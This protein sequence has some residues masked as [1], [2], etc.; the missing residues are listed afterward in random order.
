[1]QQV[2]SSEQIRA[3]KILNLIP[4]RQGKA[5]SNSDDARIGFKMIFITLK[6][7]MQARNTLKHAR[8]I[9]DVGADSG[10]FLKWSAPINRGWEYVAGEIDGGP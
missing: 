6:V 9:Y 2:R 5:A 8:Y 3:T 10:Q 4:K 7:R 1:M